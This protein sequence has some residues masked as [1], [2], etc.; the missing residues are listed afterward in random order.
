MS[1]TN[2][3]TSLRLAKELFYPPPKK[4]LSIR[5]SPMQVREIQTPAI[6]KDYSSDLFL[7]ENPLKQKL[8]ESIDS[9][10]GCEIDRLINIVGI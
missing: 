8:R 6:T 1:Q 7:K 9:N 10:S 4:Y 5:P 3:A 2:K